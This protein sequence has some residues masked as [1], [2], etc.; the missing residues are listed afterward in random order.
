MVTYDIAY[1]TN[2]P[3]SDFARN[4]VL[5]SPA[6]NSPTN[7]I[8]YTKPESVL[9]KIIA[10]EL[11]GNGIL[12]S[13]YPRVADL[14]AGNASISEMLVQQGWIPEHITCFDLFVPTKPR[15]EKATWKYWNLG[16][17]AQSLR[18]G[19]RLPPEVEGCRGIYDFVIAVQSQK[20]KSELAY[21]MDFFVRPNGIVYLDGCDA[22]EE[23]ISL[24]KWKSV[25]MFYK[26]LM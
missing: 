22:P 16:M 19:D 15:V 18:R 25:G 20:G 26:K 4:I 13:I 6:T 11:T 10:E 9:S 1:S 12:P 21:I 8:D 2:E 14:F 23:W 5:R 7:L 17:L 24:E 3:L